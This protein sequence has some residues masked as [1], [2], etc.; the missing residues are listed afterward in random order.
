MDDIKTAAE[1]LET[2]KETPTA[3]LP[4]TKIF[5]VEEALRNATVNLIGAGSYDTAPPVPS[6]DVAQ[7]IAALNSLK[8]F[9]LTHEPQK[10]KTG[11]TTPPPAKVFLLDENLRNVSV[12]LLGAGT[13]S[14]IPV[15]QV[16]R[17]IGILNTLRPFDITIKKE[18]PKK[19]VELQTK[20]QEEIHKKTSALDAILKGN[21]SKKP[22]EFSKSDKDKK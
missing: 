3:T 13:F 15:A 9:N 5:I 22:D 20:S 1:Q 21:E 2:I 7:V 4:K 12:N 8:P 19:T 14:R 18:E 11:Q 10:T 17:I 16:I 6:R